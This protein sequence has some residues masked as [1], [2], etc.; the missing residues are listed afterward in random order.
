MEISPKTIA[1]AVV[2]PAAA[3]VLVQLL[4]VFLVLIAALFLVGTLNPAVAWLERRGTSRGWS[5]ALVFGALLL[6]SLL[7]MA[8]T[9]PALVEQLTTIA[10]D[11]PKI[12]A[13]L[14]DSLG[15]SRLSAPF[16]EW[17]RNARYES[18]ATTSLAKAALAYSA[19]AFEIFAYVVSAVFLALYMMV[20]RDRLRGGLFAVVPRSHHIV[21]SRVLLNLEV[22]VGG[23]IRGQVLT[24]AL[25]AAFVLALLA[26]CR[27]PNALALAAFA[28]LADVLPYIGVFLSVG[29]AVIGALAKGPVI[30]GVVLVALL[31]YEE[32][33]SRFLV[34]R[35]YGHALRLPSSVVL[36]A[37]LAGGTL[38]G[39][40]GALLA[41]PVAAAVRMLIEELRI[42]LPGEQVDD[43]ATRARDDRAEREYERRTDG[44]PA[45]QAA[46]I[47]VAIV[48]KRAKEEGGAEAATAVPIPLPREPGPH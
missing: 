9:I 7:L 29:P 17:L 27:V 22:I 47:A 44:V 25:M 12:R 6:A 2:I 45:E 48:E 42:E 38:L 3:W 18:L 28:G 30:A 31:A 4:P 26:I 46:A 39:I 33:E 24:S 21:L 16:A 14:A 23:Y 13:R 8:L 15:H 32:F 36:F 20:D 40:I 35:V 11:E 1:L 43:A 10:K 37:L 5:I 19:R 34:P 41:L